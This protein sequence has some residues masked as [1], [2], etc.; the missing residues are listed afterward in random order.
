[1]CHGIS[2]MDHITPKLQKEATLQSAEEIS[3]LQVDPLPQVALKAELVKAHNRLLVGLY[4][5]SQGLFGNISKRSLSWLEGIH[6]SDISVILR[7]AEGNS[8]KKT[9]ARTVSPGRQVPA[10]RKY[11]TI[12]F[13][14]KPT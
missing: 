10:C 11:C 14:D 13:V 8:V 4:N 12:S 5:F 6:T 3:E 2:G 9:P 1:M 7:H